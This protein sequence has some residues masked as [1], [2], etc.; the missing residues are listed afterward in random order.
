MKIKTVLWGLATAA[1]LVSCSGAKLS[2]ANEQYARGEFYDAAQTYRKVYSKTNPSKERK[3][4]GEIAFKMAE[5]YRRINMAPRSS[6]AYQNAIRYDYPDS[7]ALFYLARSQQYEGKYKEA[8]KNYQAYLETNPQSSLAKNGIRGCNLAQQWKKTPTRYVVKKATMFNSRRSDFAPMFLGEDFDQV[9]F[10][11][12]T[13]KAL[14]KNK[15]GI[16]GTKNCDL[17]FSKKNERGAWQKPEPIEGDVNTEDDEGVISFSPDGT[18]MYLTKARREPNADT[19]VEIYTSTRT[20]AQWSAPQKYEIT[21]DTLSAFGHPAVSPDGE[22]LYFVSDMPGGYGGKDIWRISL[23]EKEGTLE[24]LGVQI[25]TPGDEMFPYIRSNGDLYFSSDG[26][27]GM[28]GLDIFKAKMNDSGFWQIE[29]MKAP[30]NSQA[31]D[32]GITFGEEESGFFSSN[33][34][35]G[36]GYDNIYS[37]EL[38]SISVWISGTVIDKDDEPVPDAIIRIVGNDG[39]NQKEFA[40]KD[41]SFRFKLDRGVHYVML[42][43]CRGY[44]NSK[45]EFISDNEEADAEYG[46]N[47]VLA[48]ISKPILIENIFYDF[49][50][51]TLRPESE[52]S[53]NELVKMLNDNPNVSIELGAHTDLKGSEQYNLR[54]SDRRA[55]SVVDYLIKSGINPDRLQPKGYGESRPKVITK[56]LATQYPQFKEGDVL[57]EKYIN[58]LSPE[59][60]EIANQINRRTE[61]QVLSITWNLY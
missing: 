21:A 54:L 16:T 33:R 57:D 51:A 11:S 22:F 38:P 35:D 20:G 25:N 2:V 37:F 39:S 32:F 23:T 59:D 5:C 13:E 14:G 31:D 18:T 47:F 17:F 42:A 6:A 55:R 41:G 9:Y 28:G 4:R 27:P 1:L 43:S 26:H 24:N 60:Q 15:S 44:L 40:R 10:S 53:L 49:D 8:I 58:G 52:T 29:N 34:G 56:K 61:F 45:Q 36:R 3:L 50:R 7:M 19:S 30:I 46:V 12:S 48:S